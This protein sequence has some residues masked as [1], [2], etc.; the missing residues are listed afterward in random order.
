M[1]KEIA[2]LEEDVRNYE[3]LK[4]GERK[5]EALMRVEVK[6]KKGN[7][8]GSGDGRCETVEEVEWALVEVAKKIAEQRFAVQRLELSMNHASDSM[9]LKEQLSRL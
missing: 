9:Q 8:V 1:V 5:L 4:S 3:F 6:S 2:E 7:K